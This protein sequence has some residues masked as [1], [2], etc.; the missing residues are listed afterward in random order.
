MKLS[1]SVMLNSPVIPRLTIVSSITR[2]TSVSAMPERRYFF[3]YAESDQASLS[4]GIL[5]E[6]QFDQTDRQAQA[7]QPTVEITQDHIDVRHTNG[8]IRA[9][10]GMDF[11]TQA[12]STARIA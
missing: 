5:V 11:V 4:N 12:F 3:D 10:Y 2:S 1:S 6:Q 8:V 7:C 9:G